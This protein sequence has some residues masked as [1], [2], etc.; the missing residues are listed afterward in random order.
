MVEDSSELLLKARN[1]GDFL[2]YFPI[3]AQPQV[4]NIAITGR[5]V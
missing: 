4:T 5:D 2:L 1:R 3:N